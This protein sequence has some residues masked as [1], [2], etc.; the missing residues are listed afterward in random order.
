MRSV[1]RSLACLCVLMLLAA[2]GTP[3]WAGEAPQPQDFASQLTLVTPSD[4]IKT[5][6][7]V[8]TFVD[9]DTVHFHVPADVVGD[10]V[11]KARF[12]AVNTPESTGRIEEYGKKAS[13]FTREKLENAVSILLE[14]DDGNWNLDT[15]GDRYLVWVWYQPAEGAAYRNLNVELL[16]NGL[17]KANATANNRYGDVASNALDAARSAKLNVFSGQKD[18]DFYYGDAIE[19]TLRELRC[20][21][22]AYAGKKVA[23]NGVVTLNSGNSVYLEAADEETGLTFGISAYYGF[24]LSGT[25]LSILTPGNEVRIVGSM[26]YYEAGGTWQISDLTYRMM[27]PTDPGN[28]QK[29]SEGHEPAWTPTSPMV[30]AKGVVIV[31]TEDG[32]SQTFPYAQLALGTSVRMEGLTVTDA[33]TTTDED[34]S[35]KGAITLTCQA[36]GETVTVRTVPMKNADG[37]LVTQDLFLGRTIDIRGVVDLFDGVYQV[38]VFGLDAITLHD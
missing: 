38:K 28:I 35:S 36:E 18:P 30:F 14:S 9:G 3:A 8:K 1:I 21:P 7:T 20:N 11:L 27:K 2:S 32:A 19:L 10:G 6:A 33:F 31:G 23:F 4:S 29:L 37:S 22:E 24:S 34:S 17:A 26:Q 12:L 15:T 16:Q 25:G 13:A 5:E